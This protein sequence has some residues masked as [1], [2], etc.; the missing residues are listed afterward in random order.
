MTHEQAKKR[1]RLVCA[2]CGIYNRIECET[3]DDDGNI[4]CS[5]TECAYCGRTELCFSDGTDLMRM[6]MDAAKSHEEE[7]DARLRRIAAD[8]FITDTRR[9]W[10]A[11]NCSSVPNTNAST[12]EHEYVERF[13]ELYKDRDLDELGEEAD[14]ARPSNMPTAHER[15]MMWREM[16]LR[17][18]RNQPKSE[19][20]PSNTNDGEKR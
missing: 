14:I 1:S 9:G 3:C 6:F 7:R 13:V 16:K 17:R 11:N 2:H 15:E 18:R 20:S 12:T 10:L 5:W 19:V 4:V 8:R